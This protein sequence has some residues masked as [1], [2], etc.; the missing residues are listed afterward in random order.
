M[1][2]LGLLTRHLVFRRDCDSW[3]LSH[4]SLYRWMG[5]H[6]F[7]WTA[8]VLQSYHTRRCSSWLVCS[9][10]CTCRTWKGA[11]DTDWFSI[12]LL[13]KWNLLH[14]LDKVDGVTLCSP[15]FLAQ[16]GFFEDSDDLLSSVD[17]EGGIVVG[18]IV[19]HTARCFTAGW[20]LPRQ[21]W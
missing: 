7:W 8:T 5:R 10:L 11:K 19:H 17:T 3:V 16:N 18:G 13:R 1:D 20:K 4:I 2:L 9:P 6:L 21:H 12:A 15:S 14:I